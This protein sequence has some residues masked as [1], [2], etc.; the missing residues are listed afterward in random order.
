MKRNE[1]NK[2]FQLALGYAKSEIDDY[3]VSH[4][5]REMERCHCPAK[6]V[7]STADQVFE[8]MN[9]YATDNGLDEFFWSDEFG[10]DEV[11]CNLYDLMFG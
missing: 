10:D 7:D 6:M 2:N 4:V 1:I 11:I 3:R 5:I 8:L 9:E